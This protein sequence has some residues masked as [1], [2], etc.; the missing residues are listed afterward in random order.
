MERLLWRK[1]EEPKDSRTKRR[2]KVPKDKDGGD[3]NIT[4][5]NH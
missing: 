5:E 3:P 1:K 2:R 4:C